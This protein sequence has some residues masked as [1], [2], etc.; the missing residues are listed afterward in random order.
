M[1]RLTSTV[2]GVVVNVDDESASTLGPEWVAEGEVI[3]APSAEAPEPG[4]DGD[5]AE[6]RG[7]ATRD[8]WAEYAD[9]LGV[10]YA[11]DDKREDI[12]AAI[13]AAAEVAAATAATGEG[14]TPGETW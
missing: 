2:T 7:N 3:E 14:A 6:P 12:K 13:T 5:P 1:G 10:E 9:S 4:G 8:A 11:E